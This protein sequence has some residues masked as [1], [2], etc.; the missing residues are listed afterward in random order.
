MH[1]NDVVGSRAFTALRGTVFLAF[2]QAV[3]ACQSTASPTVGEDVLISSTGTAELVAIESATGR[4]LARPGPIPR[5]A[6]A[7]SADGALAFHAGGTGFVADRQLVGLDV[8]SLRIAW[9][10]FLRDLE[11]RSEVAGLELPSP[12]AVAPTPDG[13]RLLVT[14]AR[15]DDETGIAVLH[16]AT[17]TPTAFIESFVVPFEGMVM[18]AANAALPSGGVAVATGRPTTAGKSD[19]WLFILDGNALTRV[20]SVRLTQ[21]VNHQWADLG[22]V[23]SSPSGTK[24]YVRGPGVVFGY[25]VVNREMLRT[26][27]IP[28]YSRLYVAPADGS[29]LALDHGDDRNFAG[30][31]FLLRIS[32]DLASVD[33]FDL[34]EA[35]VDF[36]GPTIQAAAQSRDGKRFYVLIGN[37]RIGPL[38]P[39]QKLRIL[40]VDIASRR[41]IRSL[42]LDTYGGGNL[43]VQ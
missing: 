33:T 27:R 21:G 8:R 16:A 15:R 22:P 4:V 42:P 30:S 41:I 37:E 29:L 1:R 17:R 31:G 25:D 14:P 2:L 43:L 9:R 39:G 3:P 40:V 12:T 18:L 28:H 32:A 20:D 11:A 23:V 19:G 5:F 38:F 36:Q 24:V 34:R 26:V 35:S 7:R 13:K 6:F 10:D